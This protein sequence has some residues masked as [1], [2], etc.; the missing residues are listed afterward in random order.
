MGLLIHNIHNVQTTYNYFDL[1]PKQKQR[2]IEWETR[3]KEREKE[4]RTLGLSFEIQE[5][6]IFSSEQRKWR[7]G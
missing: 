5:S 6:I 1:A 3:A 7:G 4:E 2:S